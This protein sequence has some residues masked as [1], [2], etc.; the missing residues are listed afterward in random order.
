M[1]PMLSGFS[2]VQSMVSPERRSEG[3]RI[4][5]ESYWDVYHLDLFSFA[6]LRLAVPFLSFFFFF[7]HPL[8]DF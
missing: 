1:A 5:T 7:K 6:L 3:R 4:I 2:F 8:V